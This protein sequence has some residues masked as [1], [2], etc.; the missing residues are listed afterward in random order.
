MESCKNTATALTYSK[1]WNISSTGSITALTDSRSTLGQM[2]IT[3]I[4]RRIIYFGSRFACLLS[5]VLGPEK[6]GLFLPGRKSLKKHRTILRRIE[7][8]V[9]YSEQLSQLRST[10]KTKINM[11]C[12]PTTSRLVQMSSK[13][14][15]KMWGT[16]LIACVLVAESGSESKERIPRRTEIAE[17]LV[18]SMM[19][20]FNSLTRTNT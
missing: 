12:F 6:R 18:Q 5:Q 2:D 19:F 13:S 15:T 20:R 7:G 10:K 11:Q 4:L 16:C 8:Q 14:D 1:I 3:K 17:I 9:P